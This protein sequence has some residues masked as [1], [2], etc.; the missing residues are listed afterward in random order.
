PINAPSEAYCKSDAHSDAPSGSNSP[1]PPLAPE[2]DLPIALQKGKRT[3][4]YPISAFVS[5]NGLSTSS[6][7]FIAN[8]DSI[9]VPKTVG[10]ALAHS[11]WRAG[12]IE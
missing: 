2:L 1:P 9:S 11:G 5:Y 8:L 3:C 12:M 7:A 6:H 10:E 4:R